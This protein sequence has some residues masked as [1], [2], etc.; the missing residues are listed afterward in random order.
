M[1]RTMQ[2]I[3]AGPFR[4]PS[5]PAT[6]LLLAAS[7]ALVHLAARL[8]QRR[9]RHD[10]PAPLREVAM[11]RVGGRDGAAVFEDGKLVAWLPD[12]QRL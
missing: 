1:E 12:V 8:E 10:R 9:Q 4:R 2:L 6:G 11:Q 7:A 5:H 3:S